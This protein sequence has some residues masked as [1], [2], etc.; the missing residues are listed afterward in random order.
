[1]E[2]EEAILQTVKERLIECYELSGLS[3]ATAGPIPEEPALLVLWNELGDVRLLQQAIAL[4]RMV[5]ENLN[6]GYDMLGDENLGSAVP[7]QADKPWRAVLKEYDDD[8]NARART[9]EKAERVLGK[10]LEET[11]KKPSFFSYVILD[12]DDIASITAAVKSFPKVDY[13]VAARLLW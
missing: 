4:A 13:L 9:K 11:G 5:K 1:M 8:E 12:L 6:S 2:Q 3:T 7:G 10:L